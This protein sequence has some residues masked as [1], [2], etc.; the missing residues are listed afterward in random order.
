MNRKI[1]VIL[2]YVAMVFEILSTLLLTP[3]IIRTLGDAEYGVYKLSASVV[4]YLLLLDLGI[5][6]AVTRYMAKYRVAND[7]EN[8]KKFLGVTT[9]YYAFIAL[10]VLL[11]GFVL[12]IVFPNV[13]ATG[14]TIEETALGQRLLVITVMNAAITLGTSGYA[15]VIIAYEKF[16][17]SKGV[18]IFSVILRIIFT[19]FMLRIG[20]GSLGIV[21]VN[22]FLT[23]ITRLFYVCYVLFILKLKPRFRNI[24]FVFIKEVMGYSSFIL[25]QMVATHLNS[26]VDQILLGTMVSGSVVII[27]IYSIGNQIVQYFQSIGSAFTGVI[28]PGVVKMVENMSKPEQLCDEMIRV[29]RII[30]MVLSFVWICF[31]LYGKQFIMLWVGK[32]YDYAFVIACVLMLAYIFILTE[33]IGS[34]ILWAKNQH[35]EQAILK[36]LIVSLNVILTI[37]LIR[38]KPL[39]GATIGTFISL[40]LGDVVVMNIVFKK[41]IGIS[42]RQYY[43]GLLKGIFPCL[44]ISAVVGY[45]F[46]W[47]GLSGWFGFV[48]NISVMIGIYCICMLLLGLNH[49][50]KKL[51][52]SIF[53]KI[54]KRRK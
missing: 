17:V 28:M 29:G 50:E 12:I 6:N 23:I 20:F 40:V 5:G 24:S 16:A 14:L 38:W 30:F 7:A 2:S 9:L 21:Y 33:S 51:V 44:I 27:G 8:S 19:Y 54:F 31:L 11:L 3:F 32:G 52:G 45:L 41:K 13:F 46:S 47:I 34:Q 18:T 22:L 49:Y 48:I 39:L 35:K 26:S 15:N 1:G 42:L 43:I 53:N 4:S 10:L 25:L 36:L 37:F